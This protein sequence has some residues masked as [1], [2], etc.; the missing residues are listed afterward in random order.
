MRVGIVTG[1][2]A[3]TVGAQMQGMV[4]GDPVNTAAAVQSVAAPGQVWVDETTR[5]LTSA[6]ISYADVGSHQLKGKAEPMPLWAARAVVAHARAAPSAPTGSRRPWSAATASCAWS[7]RRSTGVEESG[8]PAL[9]VVVGRRREW[10]SR[11]LGWEFSKYTDGLADSCRWHCR[12]VRVVRRGCRLLRVGRGGAEPARDRPR[13]ARSR[14]STT[15]ELVRA[16]ASRRTSPTPSERAWLAPRLGALLGTAGTSSFQ[17]DDLFAAWTTFFERVS[18][19]TEPVVMLIDDA[20]YADEGLVLFVEH[21]LAAASF[22]CFVVLLARPELLDR[23]SGAGHQPPG[24][25][26]APRRR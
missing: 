23:P 26:A 20:Q 5:L 18:N 22:P 2:V 25:R 4:A 15:D 21:L 7:R 14:G 12:Q 16:R 1:E 24:D 10:A 11:A 9:L 3:V 13:G 17:R 8:R 19:G 6:S